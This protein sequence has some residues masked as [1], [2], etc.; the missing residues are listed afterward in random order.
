MA[1]KI[2]RSWILGKHDEHLTGAL[3]MQFL[4]APVSLVASGTFPFFAHLYT[5]TAWTG[6]HRRP[7]KQHRHLGMALATRRPRS[8]HKKT[9]SQAVID[10]SLVAIVII[11]DF[12][13]PLFACFLASSTAFSIGGTTADSKEK[14]GSCSRCLFRGREKFSCV[15]VLF[16]WNPVHTLQFPGLVGGFVGF[17]REKIGSVRAC[18][19]FRRSK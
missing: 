10:D 4:F 6:S 9:A 14:A 19:F 2:V 8:L 1:A 16:S 7:K 18:V 17:R 12:R 3:S 15:F 5:E 11:H 13:L